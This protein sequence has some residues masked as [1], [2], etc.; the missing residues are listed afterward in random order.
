M[1]MRTVADTLRFV[2]AVTTSSRWEAFLNTL[3]VCSTASF[4]RALVSCA[5]FDTSAAAA[6]YWRLGSRK[7][8]LTAPICGELPAHTTK[9]IRVDRRA[10]PYIL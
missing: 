2:L 6:P 10:L 3:L 9:T 7:V 5:H 8:L 4:R 1:K